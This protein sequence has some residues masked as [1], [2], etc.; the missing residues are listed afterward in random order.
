MQSELGGENEICSDSVSDGLLVLYGSTIFETQLASIN[1]G[2]GMRVDTGSN[3]FIVVG[4]L[5][6][7][8]AFEA[9]L[10]AT[11]WLYLFCSSLH[12]SSWLETGPAPARGPTW[13]ST[14][15]GSHYWHR[16]SSQCIGNQA[17]AFV[18]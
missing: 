15:K 13:G 3:Y 11:V 2:I 10:Q 6:A 4:T 1:P 17:F 12:G 16:G 18:D 5:S 8:L 7:P 9:H 14:W